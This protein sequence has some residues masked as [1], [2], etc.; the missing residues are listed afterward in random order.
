MRQLIPRS[1]YINSLLLS[2]LIQDLEKGQSLCKPHPKV[3][4]WLINRHKP[5]TCK[6]KKTFS[7]NFFLGLK[8][9]LL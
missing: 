2:R 5:L 7:D 3:P 6:I 8:E 1:G 4:P 9:M